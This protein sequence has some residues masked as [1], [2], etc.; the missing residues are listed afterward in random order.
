MY[1]RS[2]EDTTNKHTIQMMGQVKNNVIHYFNEMENILAY[3]ANDDKVTAFFAAAAEANAADPGQAPLRADVGKVIGIYENRHPEIAGILMVNAADQYVSNKLDRMIRDP[4]T[5]ESWYKQAASNPD[6]VLLISKPIGRNIKAEHNYSADQVLSF[7]Q[8]I[9]D[10]A[11]GGVLGVILLDME[12]SIIQTAI[13]SVSLGKSGFVYITDAQGGIVY[14]PVNPI[15]YRINNEWLESGY[16]SIE[17]TINNRSYQIMQDRFEH[18]GWKIVVVFPFDEAK[19]FVIKWQFYTVVIVLFTVFLA[20]LVSWFFTNSIIKPVRKL[21]RIMQRVEEGELHLRFE[22]RSKD[23]IGQLGDSFNKMVQ[24]IEQLIH[25]V[26][27]EQKGKR[28]AELKVLQEQIKPHFLYNTLDTIQWMAQDRDA[29][30]I[31]EIVIALT[32]LFRIGLS[33]GNEHIPLE[34]EIKHVESYLIIQMMRY[35]GKLSYQINELPYQLKKSKVL[36]LILQ[37]L[38]E[39][40]IYHG[41]KMKKGKGHI[42][43]ESEARDGKLVL[44]VIDNGL[45]MKPE[46]LEIIRQGVIHVGNPEH[47]DGFGLFNVNERIRLTYGIS[48]G[49][50]VHSEYEAGTRVEVFLPL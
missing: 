17:K 16:T 46:Q 18:I 24:E 50:E 13:E 9:K 3:L 31:V 15:V 28:E 10:P 35:E 12:L 20:V 19:S 39:N 30:D 41:I 34:D 47:K 8:A 42:R 26:Y 43:I 1:K 36:K 2:I 4:L 48:Y 11:T 6:E 29:D 40:A 22:G 23:E 5:S 44:S 14:S 33:R 7:V 25:M 32:N 38:V 37:P 49:I 45:G 27:S 21:R